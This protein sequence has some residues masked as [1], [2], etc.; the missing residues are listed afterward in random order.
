MNKPVRRA[1]PEA[2]QAKS[3][4]ENSQ[5]NDQAAP[6]QEPV[7]Q[8]LKPEPEPEP[9]AKQEKPSVYDVIRKVNEQ[10]YLSEQHGNQLQQLNKLHDFK[11][12]INN[13]TT[14]KLTNGDGGNDFSSNDPGAVDALIDL[15]IGN[16]KRR[17]ADIETALLTA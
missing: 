16:L 1:A 17:I 8:V 6:T 9:E 13:N 3:Q 15:C 12:R 14:L 4:T 7:M 10:F 2:V 11:S 5:A